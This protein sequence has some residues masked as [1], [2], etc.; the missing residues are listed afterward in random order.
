MEMTKVKGRAMPQHTV[1]Q[2]NVLLLSILFREERKQ[3]LQQERKR[4]AANFCCFFSFKDV[5][6]PPFSRAKGNGFAFS[7]R[8]T[9][10]FPLQANT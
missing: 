5:T 2:R 7:E 6:Y 3:P 10:T 8:I 9:G 1:S 4:Q